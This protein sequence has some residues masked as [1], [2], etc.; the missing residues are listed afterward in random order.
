[1]RYSIALP[2]SNSMDR[3]YYK[4]FFSDTQKFIASSH[5]QIL[6]NSV[7]KIYESVDGPKKVLSGCHRNSIA[8]FVSKS[9]GWIGAWP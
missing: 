4:L 2:A 3:S 1:M 9:L 7:W 6:C 5:P 8:A